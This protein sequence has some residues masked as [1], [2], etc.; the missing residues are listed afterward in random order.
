MSG[1][2]F[3]KRNVFCHKIFFTLTNSVDPDEMP[4]H[5]AFHLGLHCMLFPEYKG[6]IYSY[7]VHALYRLIDCLDYEQSLLNL[8]NSCM[9][10]EH[11]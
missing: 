6:L 1:Y 4:H 5:A 10:A 7:R 11:I 2:S 8:L 9:Q 3:I